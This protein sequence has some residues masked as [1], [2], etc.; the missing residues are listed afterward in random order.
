MK[1]LIFVI[2][3]SLFLFSCGQKEVKSVSEPVAEVSEEVSVDPSMSNPELFL[4]SGVGPAF[5]S[6]VKT[7]NFELAL[8]F[9]SKESIDKHGSEVIL[10]KYKSLKTNYILK[11]VSTSKNG[12]ET[13][14]R[15]T[16]N[17][18]ATSK[19]KDFIVVIEN[20]SCKIL[21]PDNL[22]EFLK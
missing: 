10:N 2:S 19:F 22:E 6:F 13:I 14:L 20:D 9:T 5:M 12:A 17:E 1:S 18:F 8:Q 3:T 15:Y 11:K 21:L 16:T 4:G 7:Q